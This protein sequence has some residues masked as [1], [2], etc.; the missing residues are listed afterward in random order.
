MPHKVNP[1]DFENSEGN[2]GIANALLD[3]SPTNCPYR[4]GNATSPIRRCC[5]TSGVAVSH[6]FIAWQSLSTLGLDRIDVDSARLLDE[7]NDNWSFWRN[8]FKRSCVAMVSKART[9][10]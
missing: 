3:S 6:T 9:N 8:P 7:L 10:N 2:L 1:I 5:A 4:G